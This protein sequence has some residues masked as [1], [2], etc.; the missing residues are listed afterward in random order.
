MQS[1]SNKVQSDILLILAVI[2]IA[3]SVAFSF[4]KYYVVKD[5]LLYVKE[6]CDPQL[7]ECLSEE[8]D[9]ED[10]RCAPSEDGL[11]HYK[12]TYIQAGST[13]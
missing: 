13:K 3:F 10:P 11:M 8:C 4:Y 5:Y 6:S 12:E 1:E 2:M 9:I 7:E